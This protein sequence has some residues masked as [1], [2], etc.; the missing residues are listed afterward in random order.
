VFD[1]EAA[2]NFIHS[3]HRYPLKTWSCIYGIILFRA[4]RRSKR[5]N[6]VEN[7]SRFKVQTSKPNGKCW[8][9]KATPNTLLLMTM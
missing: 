6:T 1:H 5:N 7:C 8:V 9:T 3:V 4:K 2:V